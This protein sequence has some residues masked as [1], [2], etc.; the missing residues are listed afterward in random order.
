MKKKML[1][2]VAALG[3]MLSMGVASLASAAPSAVAPSFMQ[4]GCTYGFGQPI[5]AVFTFYVPQ[6]ACPYHYWFSPYGQGTLLQGDPP[7]SAA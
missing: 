2:G 4:K 5:Y 7:P 3:L 6:A 1:L